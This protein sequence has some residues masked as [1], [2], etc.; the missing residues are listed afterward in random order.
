MNRVRA[1]LS[2]MP[3]G[4]QVSVQ[5]PGSTSFPQWATGEEKAV[6]TPEAVLIATRPDT[7]GDVVV[8]ILEGSE[9]Q[10]GELVFDGSLA[11]AEA[12]ILEFGNVISAQLEAVSV[13]PAGDVSLR[14]YVLPGDAP[15]EVRVLL[16]SRRGV[17]R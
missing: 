10:E 14:I 1:E 11:V 17:C 2:V 16:P 5:V 4:G 13:G 8:T 3:L 15:R 9:D 6:S 7:E 12:G